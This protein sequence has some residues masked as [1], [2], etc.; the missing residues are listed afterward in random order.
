MKKKASTCHYTINKVGEN[1][2]EEEEE[3]MKEE[4]HVC[5]VGSNEVGSVWGT[6]IVKYNGDDDDDDDDDDEDDHASPQ[7]R[8]HVGILD[9]KF[10][11]GLLNCAALYVRASEHA[12][13]QS[14]H[15]KAF[16]F[17]EPMIAPPTEKSTP[18]NATRRLRNSDNGRF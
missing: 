6:S 8:F 5:S 3:A 7:I 4:S 12:C 2:W 17:G 1:N 15:S 18:T 16:L 10:S 14:A 9:I 13:R 11:V